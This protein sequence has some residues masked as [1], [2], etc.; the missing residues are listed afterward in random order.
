MCHWC[1]KIWKH[2]K[3]QKIQSNAEVLETPY[4]LS[5]AN[6]SKTSPNLAPRLKILCLYVRARSIPALSTNEFAKKALISG[7]LFWYRNRIRS[8]NIVPTAAF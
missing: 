3:T 8:L 7:A 6:L 1:A 5:L 2:T 4:L